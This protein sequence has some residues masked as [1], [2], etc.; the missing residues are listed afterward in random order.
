M[1]SKLWCR[2]GNNQQNSVNANHSGLVLDRIGTFL[3]LF[4]YLGRTTNRRNILF[5]YLLHLL[6]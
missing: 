4:L 3:L 2:T 5:G 6:V 1:G